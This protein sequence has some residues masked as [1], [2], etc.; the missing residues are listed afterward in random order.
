M[1]HPVMPMIISMT[2]MFIFGS[3]VIGGHHATTINDVPLNMGRMWI[4][5]ALAGLSF[6][7]TIFFGWEYIK[8]RNEALTHER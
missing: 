1:K 4:Y 2:L 6:G 8:A 7:A 3:M 5:A